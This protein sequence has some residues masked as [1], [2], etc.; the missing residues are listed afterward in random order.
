[1]RFAAAVLA[2][3]FVLALVAGA[4]GVGGNTKALG[5]GTTLTVLSGDVLIRHG[6][7]DFAPA[8]DGEVLS[9]GDAIR[10]GADGRAILT[11]FEGSTVT[12]EPATELAIDSA[13]S[14][15]DGGTVVLMT[16]TLGRT[17]HVVTKLI[18]SGSKYEVRTPA[19]TASVRGTEFQVDADDAATTVTTTEGTVV[20]HVE[21]PV[22]PGTAVD[23]PVTA[24][25]TQTQPRNAPPA[26]ARTAPEPERKVTVTVGSSNTL[27]VDPLGRANGVTKDGKVVVQTPGAQVKR[28]GDKIVVTLPNL[29]DG[30]LAAQ[31]DKKDANDDGD[32][33]VTTKVEEQGHATVI[34][35]RAV[36]KG[37]RKNAGV[38]LKR[39]TDGTTQGRTLD[40]NEKKTLPAAKTGNPQPPTHN[41][42][43]TASPASSNRAAPSAERTASS[44]PKATP[45]PEATRTPEALRTAEPT[46]RPTVRVDTSPTLPTPRIPATPTLPPT[47]RVEAT[48]RTEP[49]TKQ[50]AP[51]RAASIM[52]VQ[53]TPK[54]EPNAKPVAVARKSGQPATHTP[55]PKATHRR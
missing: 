42:P 48:P 12:I 31:V 37:D 14:T 55:D 6:A 28:D 16:Q 18:T 41:V 36:V 25:T 39:T 9:E 3:G 27:I 19:S 46:P 44:A 45:A 33:Q 7:A 5:A 52:S 54:P 1:L 13:N 17:W 50:E 32:V 38:E 10:T 30:K 24:G 34:D 40:E 51:V 43:R 26:P 47:P 53:E 49:V 11:Y 15:A 29:P 35:D 22:R 2:L 8:A 21:D 23:V 4:A 20:A